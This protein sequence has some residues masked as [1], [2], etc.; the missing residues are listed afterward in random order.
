MR[1]NTVVECANIRIKE[2]IINSSNLI[3]NYNIGK[4]RLNP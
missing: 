2:I 1:K 4:L 3:L